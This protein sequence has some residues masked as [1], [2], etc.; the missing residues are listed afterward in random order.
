MHVEPPWLE[1]LNPVTLPMP[2]A[3]FMAMPRWWC[4]HR[5]GG[6]TQPTLQQRRR[7][8]AGASTA[9]MTLSFPLVA[10]ARSAAAIGRHEQ[11]TTTGREDEQGNT[12]SVEE[13]QS[14]RR[15]TVDLVIQS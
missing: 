11:G 12:T 10:M 13:Q 9:A 8:S 3:A 1:S 5:G 4:G 15:R 2:G 7:C 14:R 6:R